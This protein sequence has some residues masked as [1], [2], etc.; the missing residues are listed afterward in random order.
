MG[1]H[2]FRFS[3][4]K[5][6]LLLASAFA[7]IPMIATE[8]AAVRMDLIPSA[9]IEE[10]WESNVFSSSTNE[11]SSLSTRVTPELA[12][13]LTT[14]DNVEMRFSG[15]YEKVWYHD[16]EANEANS[17]TYNFRVNSSGALRL[18][19]TFFMVPSVSYINTTDSFRR[20]QLAPSGDPVIPPVSITNYGDTKTETIA[21]G[22]RF[23]YLVTP[24]VTLG[25]DG[26]YSRQRFDTPTDNAA[27]T[28]LT[29]SSSFGA[30]ASVSYQFSPRTNLGVRLSGSHDTYE[31]NPITNEENPDTDTLSG[32]ITFG[33]RFTPTVRL[34]G[35]VGAQ[36][37]R[38][39]ETQGTPEE[40]ETAPSGMFNLTYTRE[41][42]TATL[43]G[44]AVYSGGSGFG[45]ATRQYTAGLGFSDRFA[46]DW[47]WNLSGAYQVSRSAFDTDA[48][49]IRSINGSTGFQYRPWRWATVEL[50]GN[51]HRQ[52]S[53]GQFG[54][55]LNNYSAHLGFT[56]ANPY[57]LF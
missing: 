7:L 37:I 26:N 4:R 48:E 17:E 55:D 42:V 30:G 38:R 45:Q 56:A 19:P 43:F 18:T 35:G 1:R 51:I 3:R 8:A 11:V 47:T 2:G 31:D 32:H 28:G 27:Q 25:M 22:V 57:I 36:H 50:T 41:T 6:G 54:E 29:D 9:R 13:R 24:N 23:D 40:S 49:D 46:R 12:L 21:G 33:Y 52:T 15:S 44:S 39:E 16:S 14:T 10:G 53:S 20:T 5:G 34:D